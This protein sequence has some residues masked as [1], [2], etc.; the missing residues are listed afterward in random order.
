ME[1]FPL[2]SL[3]YFLECIAVAVHVTARLRRSLSG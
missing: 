2:F 1:K 3:L